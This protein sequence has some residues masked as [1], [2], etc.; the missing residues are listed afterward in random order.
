MN[1]RKSFYTF[2]MF[3]LFKVVYNC[4]RGGYMKSSQD[5]LKAYEARVE[6]WKSNR[7][8]KHRDIQSLLAPD[9]LFLRSVIHPTNRREAKELTRKVILYLHEHRIATAQD[10][11]ESIGISDNPFLKRV[12]I[13]M[14][15]GIVRRESKKF[16]MATPRLDELVEKKYIDKLCN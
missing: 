16:Y 10:M 11:Y 14:N 9:V 7:N 3:I 8:A 13:L 12:K 1:I 2:R 5:I 15:F 4:L 6:Q